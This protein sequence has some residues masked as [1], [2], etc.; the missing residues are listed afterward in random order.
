MS[1]TGTCGDVLTLSE[2]QTGDPL[3]VSISIPGDSSEVWTFTAAEQE[4][5]AVTGARI[6]DPTQLDGTTLPPLTLNDT[7]IGLST[8]GSVTDTSGFTHGISYT[9]TRTS[10]SPLTC[11]NV[12][13]W[14]HPST[15]P[16]PTTENPTARPDSAPGLTGNNAAQAGTNDVTIQLDQETLATD[17]GIPSPDQFS[18]VVG[19]AARTV[20]AVTITNDS[21]AAMATLD[22]TLSG[23]ALS[24]GPTMTVSYHAPTGTSDPA[25]QDLEGHKTLLFGP[26]AVDIS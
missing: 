10:P 4:Y 17:Q 3:A 24:V 19:G 8:T 13:Y 21:P 20:T 7:G 23:A 22:L 1:A 16:G 25:L 5:G 2:P 6:G 18:V 11:T 12:A 14:T 26:T 15:V 9:A